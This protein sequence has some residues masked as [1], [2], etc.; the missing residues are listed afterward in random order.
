VD[1]EAQ[2]GSGPAGF[3]AVVGPVEFARL[4]A[5]ELP[6]LAVEWLPETESTS[7]EL[8][9][10]IESGA[11]AGPLLLGTDRQTGGRGTRGRAW[12]QPAGAAGQDIAMTLAWPLSDAWLAEPRL[13]LLIGAALALA[14][15]RATGLQLGLKWPNDLLL[16]AGDGWRKCGGLLLETLPGA[17]QRWLLCG[18][19]VNC[20]SAPEDYPARLRSAVSTLRDALGRRLDRAALVAALAG[21]LL[22]L[23][24]APDQART[25]RLLAVWQQ[26]DQTRQVR[27]ILLRDGQRVPV[28]AEGVDIASGALRVRLPGGAVALVQSYTDL[29][30]A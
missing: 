16:R 12:L 17:G 24:P 27:Y 7:S 1:T 30:A 11:L 19:G 28:S 3:E 10:R 6:G 8:R 18:L 26:R 21:S 20:N 23:L 15:E 14:L 25:A 5:G 22:E 9:E 2:T 29:E 13:S 4:I